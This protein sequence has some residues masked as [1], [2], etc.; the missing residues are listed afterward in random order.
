MIGAGERD[1]ALGMLG[2]G[3]DAARILDADRA[4]RSANGRSAAPCAACAMRRLQ[5]S[6]RR[7]RRGIR[8][9][10]GTAGRRARPRPRPAAPISSSVSLNRPVTCAGIARRRDRHHRARLRHLARPRPAPRRRRGCGRSGSPARA[11]TSRSVIGGRDQ[12][13][14]VGGERGVGELAFARAEAGEVEAQ[15]RD[16]ERR[17]RLRR[18]ASPPARPCRR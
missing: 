8:G 16:A 13:G 14:D 12:V 9:G 4:R 2:R 1:E 18:C 15:H 3:E 6:A 7:R 11:C 10:C 5:A 17:Q